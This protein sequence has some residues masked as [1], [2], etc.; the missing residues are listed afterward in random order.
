MLWWKDVEVGEDPEADL[1]MNPQIIWVCANYMSDE[2]L[3]A[4][5]RG[6]NR[7]PYCDDLTSIQYLQEKKSLYS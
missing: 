1:G 4:V 5:A 3:F 7:L 6:W 2:Y